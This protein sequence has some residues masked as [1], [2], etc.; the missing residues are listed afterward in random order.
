MPRPS[1][2]RPNLFPKSN[3]TNTS[4]DPIFTSFLIAFVSCSLV[5]IF[6][7]VAFGPRRV[8]SFPTAVAS[9]DGSGLRSE[10]CC[11][12]TKHLEL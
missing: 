9:V 2:S 4:K 8:S 11:R 1:S 7:S 12:G 5:Y 6:L 3:L 10:E